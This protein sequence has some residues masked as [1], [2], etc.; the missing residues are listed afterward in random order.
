MKPKGSMAHS[1]GPSNNPCP[2]P[3]QPN[4][5]YSFKVH[6]NIVLPSTPRTLWDLVTVLKVMILQKRVTGETLV[7]ENDLVGWNLVSKCTTLKAC[8]NDLK[9]RSEDVS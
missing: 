6:S 1:Q 4:S 9:R 3:N 7:I 8:V 2:G 5:S